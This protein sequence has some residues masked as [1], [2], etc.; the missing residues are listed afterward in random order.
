MTIH[1]VLS[2]YWGYSSF[3]PLQEEI[4]NSVLDGN[5]TLALMP[6]GGGKSI[7]FQIP[8]M[9]SD[10]VCI[11]VSPL[12]AL[13]KDQVYNLKKK[14]I[15]A[16]AVFSGMSRREIDII[17]DNCIYGKVK[18]LYVSPER[19]N[20]E[21]FK[22]RLQKMKV[23]LI[24][25]D[26]AHCIS[27]WGYDF[28]PPYLTIANIREG[29]QG[30][31]VLA[32]TATAT[33]KV[34]KDIQEKL[35]FSKENFF[36]KSFE[37]K[38]LSYV[39][40]YEEGKLNKVLDIIQKVKGSGIIY[41]RNR[42]KTKE[43][44]EFLSKKKISVDFYHA[45]LDA[46]ARS[47]KQDKWI[48]GKCRIMVC[49]NA[50]GMGID[51]ADVRLVIHLDI[52]A[53]LEEYYQEA[54]R[55]GRDEKKSYAVLLY[56]NSDKLELEK[57]FKDAFPSED[58]IRMIYHAIGNYLQLAIGLG[59][60][61]SFDF[62]LAD[63]CT[64]YNFKSTVVHSSLKIL[65]QENKIT[66]TD[67]VFISSRLMILVNK[68]E[69]YRFEL[70]NKKYESIIKTILRSYEGLFENY[71]NIFEADI[72]KNLAI[73]KEEA[74]GLLNYLHQIK[75]ISYE[76]SKN[77]PQIIF[78]FPREDMKHLEINRAFLEQRK[79]N[80][81]EKITA[82][83]RYA[84][85]RITCRSQ[86]LLSYFGEMNSNRCGVCDVCLKRNKL[87]LNDM[88]FRTISDEVKQL[89]FTQPRSIREVVDGISKFRQDKVLKTIQWLK[90]NN[91]VEL[92]EE[93]KLIWNE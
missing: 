11:V 65:E 53:S 67:A 88:E 85:D 61:E 69:L 45:G 30:V 83:L 18:F 87:E 86:M 29:L 81:R 44:A 43:V 28:R 49:T 56:N 38:N 62:D 15:N 92:M 20:T 57:K 35:K 12:I 63:F 73:T 5:D 60:G 66:V 75:I 82:M 70:S 51:K 8:A 91:Q 39:V 40:L 10:G 84:T 22:V 90:D 7:C 78:N 41:V 37:R 27:Q 54:G 17:L 42:K 74:I 21:I 13:M 19:L 4:I 24:A 26:E 68:E 52:P 76:P 9:V 89:L 77:K 23:N 34:K 50:F 80:Y 79:K 2:K 36:Q 46:S 64:T 55:A 31:P 1:S 59:A 93:D 48:L 3:R 32:L 72:S 47:K 58:E 71:I 25:V 16:V 33:E 6:T 14:G